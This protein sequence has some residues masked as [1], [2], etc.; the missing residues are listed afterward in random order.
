MQ[1]PELLQRDLHEPVLV[2]LRYK[3]SCPLPN[4]GLRGLFSIPHDFPDNFR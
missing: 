2:R 3:I 4:Y 1:I